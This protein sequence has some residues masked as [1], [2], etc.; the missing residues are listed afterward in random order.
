MTSRNAEALV[1]RMVESLSGMDRPSQ[2]NPAGRVQSM[3]SHLAGWT[4]LPGRNNSGP[5][6]PPKGPGGNGGPPGP[7]IDT[8]ALDLI[9]ARILR[10]IEDIASDRD[11]AIAVWEWSAQVPW[12]DIWRQASRSALPEPIHVIAFAVRLLIAVATSNMALERLRRHPGLPEAD[13]SMT[14]EEIQEGREL[15]SC[16]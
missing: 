2:M 13:W 11:L 4:P 16:K 1:A 9:L 6:V 10:E 5:T 12:T 8:A 7:Y 14:P 15:A 3:V